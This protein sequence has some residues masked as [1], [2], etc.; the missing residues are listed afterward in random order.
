MR[1]FLLSLLLFVQTA[2]YAQLEMHVFGLEQYSDFM[3][4]KT[5]VKIKTYEN[6]KLINNLHAGIEYHGQSSKLHPKKN[7]D[8]ELRDEAGNEIKKAL[9]G[10]QAG[11]DFILNSL[12]YDGSYIRNAL[13]FECWEKMGYWSPDYRYLNLYVDEE[14]QG[15]Y[16]LCEKIKVDEGRVNFEYSDSTQTNY[17]F[18]LG[19]YWYNKKVF[20]IYQPNDPAHLAGGT[21]SFK[22]IYPK[23]KKRNRHKIESL[24]VYLTAVSHE[25]AQKEF[26]FGFNEDL[27]E[28]DIYL[29]S[30]IDYFLISEL[31]KNPDA[32]LANIYF[33]L[34]SINADGKKL[35]SVGPQWDY[36]LAFGNTKKEFFN[37]ANGWNYIHQ[38]QTPRNDVLFWWNSLSNLTT[39]K[40][41]CK[42]RLQELSVLFNSN[43]QH[44]NSIVDSLTSIVRPYYEMD[45]TLWNSGS[46]DLPSN[47]HPHQG[48]NQEVNSLLTFFNKRW[49]WVFSNLDQLPKSNNPVHAL[50]TRSKGNFFPIEQNHLNLN[51]P[52]NNPERKFP[53]YYTYE[54]YNPNGLV[55][56]EGILGYEIINIPLNNLKKGRYFLH[57]QENEGYYDDPNRELIRP[58]ISAVEPYEDLYYQFTVG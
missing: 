30:F 34:Q 42:N 6:G 44:F 23:H 11:D 51:Y 19:R 20:W 35:L 33:M 45:S 14:Y 15:L 4:K 58:S 2:I 48:L 13:V 53:S 50:L 32:Y 22:S 37:T 38:S 16:L 41:A 46:V 3:N 5:Q 7:Y 56:E 26:E 47:L 17:L 39:Y 12:A 18:K 52:P 55:I 8:F 25:L 43:N 49:K 27:P 57:L 31:T 36:D 24:A 21:I 9:F 10:M 29:Q 28:G 40:T 1:I 54:L